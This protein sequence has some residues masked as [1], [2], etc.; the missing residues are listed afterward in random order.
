MPIPAPALPNG[1]FAA[2]LTPFDANL[3]VDHERLVAHI[4]WLLNSGCNGV[5]LFGTTGEAN[6]ITVEE[7]MEALDA[8]VEA[9]IPAER[10]MVGTGC[11]AFPDTVRLSRHAAAH[12]VGGMLMLPPFYYKSVSDDGVFASFDAV[13]QQVGDAALRIF[14]YHFPKMSGVAFSIGLVERLLSRY[15]SAIVGMKD[16]QGSWAH[17]QNMITRF[18]GFRVFAGSERFLLQA[19]R[20]GG[21]GCV[22]A[23]VNV[24]CRRAGAVFEKRNDDR[25]EHLQARL[26]AVRAAIEYHPMV[27]A[28][29]ALTAERTEDATWLNL[30]PPLTL[31]PEFQ[32]SQL[33]VALEDLGTA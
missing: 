19:V 32:V 22:S 16:S 8:V 27:P 15:P 10:L 28:L 5:A 18:P 21:A 29:K 20:A 12:Q 33:E 23:S 26:T 4:Q 9:G 25:A 13:M 11:C 7:R 6:S 3:K 30:R 14:L 2:S 31:L 24:T 1:V 17:T